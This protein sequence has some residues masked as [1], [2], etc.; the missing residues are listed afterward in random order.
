MCTSHYCPGFKAREA[1]RKRAERFD[2]D[3]LDRR[4]ARLTAEIRLA[5]RFPLTLEWLKNYDDLVEVSRH[6]SRSHEEL[7]A[8]IATGHT[9][10]TLARDEAL[11]VHGVLLEVERADSVRSRP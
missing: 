3:E 11:A 1:R 10:L 7:A 4:A 2:Y 6:F 9:L 8:Q 5:Q